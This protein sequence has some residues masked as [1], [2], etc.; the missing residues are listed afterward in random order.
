M[1]ERSGAGT[2]SSGYQAALESDR[3]RREISDYEKRMDRI[4]SVYPDALGV[5]IGVGTAIVSADVF[6]NPEVF[7]ELWPKIVRSSA[8]AAV[9]R[10]ASGSISQTD[11]VRFLRAAH[12]MHYVR[13]PAID[14]GEEHAAAGSD[15]SV[16]ALVYG[17]AVIHMAAFPEEGS[18][19]S[20]KASGDSDRRIRV[21]R[22]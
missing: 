7:R 12:S 6:A 9:C 8:M 5:V 11:A 10:K 3:V 18:F 20:E 16:N 13:K 15:L 4:P 17:G 14:L 22:R 1:C 2:G 21:M 19:W